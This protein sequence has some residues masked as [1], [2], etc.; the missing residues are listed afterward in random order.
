M[1]IDCRG[2]ISSCE[3]A[4]RSRPRAHVRTADTVEFR[5]RQEYAKK[6]IGKLGRVPAT[7]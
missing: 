1:V 3:L 4:S 7:L 6:K 5:P 2:R